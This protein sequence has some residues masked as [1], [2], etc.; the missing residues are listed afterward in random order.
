MKCCFPEMLLSDIRDG[1]L[2]G[3]YNGT[4]GIHQSV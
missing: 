4:E 3:M 1:S 2:T